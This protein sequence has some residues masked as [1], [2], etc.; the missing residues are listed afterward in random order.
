MRERERERETKST[1]KGARRERE[2][3]RTREYVYVRSTLKCASAHRANIDC[4]MF[5]HTASQKN[6]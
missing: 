3:A 2:R 1:Q 4:N 5:G 6:V